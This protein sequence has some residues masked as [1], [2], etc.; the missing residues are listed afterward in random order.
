MPTAVKHEEEEDEEEEE[1]EEAEDGFK[2][3]EKETTVE[4]MKQAER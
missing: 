2:Q 1:E 3:T 4:L